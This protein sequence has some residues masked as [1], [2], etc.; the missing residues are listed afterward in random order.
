MKYLLDTNVCIRYLNGESVALR[1][2]FQSEDSQEMAV[3]SVGKDDKM[4]ENYEKLTSAENE[5]RI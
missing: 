3:C 5:Q 1:R 2:Q 4:S